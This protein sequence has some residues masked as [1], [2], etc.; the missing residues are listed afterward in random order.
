MTKIKV[1]FSGARRSSSFFR[2]F[3]AHPETEVVALCD[4]HEE[5]LAEAGKATGITQLFTVYERMLDQAKPDVVV[6]ASPMHFHVAQ[7]IAAL[8]R[9]IHALVHAFVTPA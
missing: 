9:D 4:L 5:T 8:Q 1:A 6:V 3:Q 7:S 2:A